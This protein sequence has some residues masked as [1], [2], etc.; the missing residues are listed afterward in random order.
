MTA[1]GIKAN[2]L[3][4]QLKCCKPKN[5][6]KFCHAKSHFVHCYTYQDRGGGGSSVQSQNVHGVNTELLLSFGTNSALRQTWKGVRMIP[7]ICAN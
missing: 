5:A 2:W 1:Q 7:A 4:K 6:I 3:Q